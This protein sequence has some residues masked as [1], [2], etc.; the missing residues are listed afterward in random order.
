M[1]MYMIGNVIVNIKM[2]FGINFKVTEKRG[3]NAVTSKK[4]NDNSK[5]NV[6]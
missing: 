1:F 6:S 2:F 4:N 5:D 3:K